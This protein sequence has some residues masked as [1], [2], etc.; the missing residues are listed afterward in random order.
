MKRLNRNMIGVDQ[1][2]DLIF[3]D[4]EEGGDMW[5]GEGPRERRLAITF[6]EIFRT[7]PVVHCALSM[8]DVAQGANL[9]A[10]VTAETVTTT[11]FELVFRTWGDTKI[12]RA[13]ARWMAIGEVADDDEWDV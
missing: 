11:S 5:T 13:R 1:G 8:W 3:S 12:A 9:R 10:D 2:E 7:P 6:S 4:F